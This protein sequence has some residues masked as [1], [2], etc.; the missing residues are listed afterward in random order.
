VTDR[1]R[2]LRLSR[3]WSQRRL[4]READISEADVS[5]IETGR[6]RPYGGQR[7][8][9]ARALGVRVRDVFGPAED[10]QRTT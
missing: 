10:G 1:L 7:R 5:R 4:A 3:G 8:R 6:L 9:L 2:H